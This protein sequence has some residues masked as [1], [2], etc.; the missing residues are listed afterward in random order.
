MRKENV[1]YLTVLHEVH[2][3]SNYWNCTLI[4]LIRRHFD[5]ENK[6]K[7]LNNSEKNILTHRAMSEDSSAT[8]VSLSKPT[9]FEIV[10]HQAVDS[11]FKP[12]W[13]YVVKILVQKYPEKFTTFYHYAEEI[14]LIFHLVVQ[15]H[16]LRR[17]GASVSENFYFLKR[18]N[19]S[20]GHVG[21]LS[22]RLQRLSLLELVLWPYIKSK[23]DQTFERVQDR[24]IR[25]NDGTSQT[26]ATRIFLSV[27]PY[28][29]FT[30]QCIFSAYQFGYTLKLL[31]HHS[32]IFHA[33]KMQLVRAS[34]ENLRGLPLQSFSTSKSF[35]QMV[36]SLPGYL[37]DKTIHLATIVMPAII[38]FLQFIEWWYSRDHEITS[39][40]TNL[41]VPPP[42][43]M[44]KVRFILFVFF[45]FY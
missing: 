39:S 4:P 23:I 20:N 36:H 44:P 17:F 24:N 45:L 26:I 31:K 21:N 14:Y 42:P 10:S 15:Q 34:A 5:N 3:E 11:V 35:W 29:H 41:P 32:P 6:N 37:M 9:I 2:H 25:A 22:K 19:V 30:I 12:A 7:I 27:Y 16:Y 28:V 40:L 43:A 18:V 1:C 38:F 33:L 13:M 8:E